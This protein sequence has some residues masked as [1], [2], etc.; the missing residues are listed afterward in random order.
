MRKINPSRIFH[1]N[2]V[3]LIHH[4]DLQNKTSKSLQQASYINQFSL[5]FSRS[6]KNNTIHFKVFLDKTKDAEPSF[7]R[8]V[9]QYVNVTYTFNQRM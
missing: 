9:D 1:P 7:V 4:M 5:N 2:F 3:F 8:Y 6:F